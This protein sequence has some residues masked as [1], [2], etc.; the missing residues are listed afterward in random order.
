MLCFVRLTNAPA[1]AAVTPVHVVCLSRSVLLAG[2]SVN[3]G[4]RTIQVSVVDT[5]CGLVEYVCELGVQLLK[6]LLNAS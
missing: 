5:Y 4:V 6:A 1:L 3:T 2:S